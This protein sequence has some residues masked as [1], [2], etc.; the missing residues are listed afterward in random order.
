[1]PLWKVYHPV[2]AYTPQ[3]KQAF[4]K[5]ITK[6]YTSIPIPAFYVGVIF[7]EVPADSFYMGG[8]PRKD[9]VRIWIDHIARTLPEPEQRAFWVKFSDEAIAPWVKD[10]G[11]DWEFH[12]DE[13]MFDLWSIHG[14]RP[15]PFQSAAE[16]RWV[17]ENKAT[18]YDWKETITPPNRGRTTA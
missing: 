6:L 14:H 3:E 1:M 10:K 17:Q 7:Q 5:A 12:I 18:A 11:F 13:T 8:E 4:S 9:F 2:G 15:P 16:A